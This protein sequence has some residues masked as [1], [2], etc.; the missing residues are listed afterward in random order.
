MTLVYFFLIK[1]NANR[2]GLDN[3]AGELIRFNE[4][5]RSILAAVLYS[6]WYKGLNKMARWVI[7]S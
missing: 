6:A 7:S 4:Q 2:F 3:V 5:N 1:V